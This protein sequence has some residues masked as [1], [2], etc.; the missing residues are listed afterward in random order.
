MLTHLSV[1]LTNLAITLILVGFVWY[2]FKNKVE[3]LENI[4]NYQSQI[5]KNAIQNNSISNNG[6]VS[7]N[8]F[9]TSQQNN[10]ID[11]IEENDDSGESSE[12]D[13]EDDEYD[14]DDEETDREGD[15]DR[16][17]VQNEEEGD[18][19]VGDEGDD[20]DVNNTE[21]D[22]LNNSINMIES[23]TKE[24]KVINI[25]LNQEEVNE[26]ELNLE[27]ANLTQLVTDLELVDKE[28]NNETLLENVET[29]IN[30][31]ESYN[32]LNVKQLKE[33]AVNKGLGDA[34]EIKNMKKQELISLVVNNK[35]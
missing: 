11:I 5:L 17:S 28:E 3:N 34:K 4:L 29:E 19:E 35:N 13:D 27:N 18:D 32:K 2:Y 26:D 20:E 22:D 10:K 1:I 33:I 7:S 15:S 24:I 25:E 12:S 8:D 31:Q 23:D 16:E 6:F 9:L 14:E 21:D 30:N